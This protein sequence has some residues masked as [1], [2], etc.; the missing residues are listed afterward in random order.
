M[1][2]RSLIAMPRRIASRK[3]VEV[4]PVV[5]YCT[6][7]VSAG[8]YEYKSIII[9]SFSKKIYYVSFIPS[10]FHKSE[11]TK[12]ENFKINDFQTGNYQK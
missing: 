6:E 7:S 9:F 12:E 3:K 10:L 8:I 2:R 4:N 11:I 1:S 5:K